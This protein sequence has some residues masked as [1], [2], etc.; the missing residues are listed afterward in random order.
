MTASAA[1]CALLFA[2]A[3]SIAGDFEQSVKEA[4][5]EIDKAK[6]V[7]YEWRD[8]R[9]ILKEA[10]KAEKAGDH[11]KAMKLVNKAKQQGIIAVVQA[12]EQANA[13]KNN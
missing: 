9:K 7:G 11:E 5:A 10:E 4:T 2:P 3:I 13:G 1:L 12:K 8:S 6:A